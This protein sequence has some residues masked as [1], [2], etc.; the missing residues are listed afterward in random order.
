MKKVRFCLLGAPSIQSTD[1]H[2]LALKSRKAKAVIGFLARRPDFSAP[3]TT[4]AA[5]LWSG[6]SEARAK[7][8][9][10]QCL[11]HINRA[12]EAC[13]CQFL[14]AEKSDLRLVPEAF[15]IRY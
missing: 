5:L 4:V 1:G 8:S 9:L 2:V 10:R 12:Q 15:E 6:S 11:R 14:L 13:G 3:R 7:A